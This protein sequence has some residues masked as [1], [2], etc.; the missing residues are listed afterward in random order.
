MCLFLAYSGT[1]LILFS[2]VPCLLE[3]L[4]FVH[5]YSCLQ[6]STMFIYGSCLMGI[7]MITAGSCKVI[8]F[9]LSK[10]VPVDMD[11]GRGTPLYLAVHCGQDKIVKILL[12]HHANV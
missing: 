6:L 5:Y 4:Q 7:I 3:L 8:E 10:G 9:L 12:D 11:F 1:S 2:S